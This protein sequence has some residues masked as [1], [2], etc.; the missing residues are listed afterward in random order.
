VRQQALTTTALFTTGRPLSERTLRNEDAA[1]ADVKQRPWTNSFDIFRGWIYS[2]RI[3]LKYPL[4]IDF[5]YTAIY[6]GH[7]SFHRIIFHGHN[8]AND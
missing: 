4:A 7:I 2:K 6:G 5:I 3:I 1:R 8:F